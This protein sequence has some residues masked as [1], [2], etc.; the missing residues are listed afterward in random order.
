MSDCETPRAAGFGFASFRVE[1]SDWSCAR[2]PS[3]PRANVR[4]SKP[5]ERV[6]FK[7]FIIS[8]WNYKYIARQKRNILFRM[9]SFY[10]ILIVKWVFDLFS[11]FVSENVNSFYFCKL[12][13]ASSRKRLKGGHIGEKRNR[14][15]A[16]N[17]SSN[18]NS[19]AIN[20]YDG[21][22]N[23]RRCS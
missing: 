8:L 9:F 12:C 23:L 4:A 20:F 1:S 21:Y 7:W 19:A 5:A 13:K 18:I 6:I 10:Y 17:F 3:T 15:G 14:A 11:T 22:G 2:T 16:I